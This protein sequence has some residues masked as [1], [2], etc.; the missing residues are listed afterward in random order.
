MTSRGPAPEWLGM[1]LRTPSA[2]AQVPGKLSRAGG[3]R[4]QGAPPPAGSGCRPGEP[5]PAVPGTLRFRRECGKLIPEK[6]EF[7]NSSRFGFARF[8]VFSGITEKPCKIFHYR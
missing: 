7:S 5:P 3:E 4:R 6:A 8:L 1:V 2:P